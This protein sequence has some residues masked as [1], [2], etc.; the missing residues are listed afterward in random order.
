MKRITAILLL[1]FSVTG[2]VGYDI[3]EILTG[4]DDVSLTWRGEDQFRYDPATCQMGYNSERNEFRAQTDNLS[5]WFVFR[6]TVW[7]TVEDEDIEADV[8]WTGQTD[9]RT[10][11]GL[12]FKVEKISKDG[13]IWLWCKSAKIGVTIMK[14]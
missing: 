10:M 3:E 9:T 1:V 13:M 6:C 8:S 4:R 12:E 14:L 2:C 5:S 11:K 7:P